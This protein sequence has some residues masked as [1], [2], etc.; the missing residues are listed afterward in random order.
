[1]S[2]GTYGVEQTH[3]FEP[4]LGYEK[5]AVNNKK[6]ARKERCYQDFAGLGF[7][8]ITTIE[9]LRRDVNLFGIVL[10]KIGYGY[11]AYKENKYSGNLSNKIHYR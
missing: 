5:A 9:I 11:N 6:F 10:L 3:V 4:G 8:C 2:S 1:M 7:D